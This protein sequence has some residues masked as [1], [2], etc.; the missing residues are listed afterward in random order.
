M[1]PILHTEEAGARLILESVTEAF[2]SLD[3]GYRFTF[4]NPTAARLL[5]R[6]DLQGKHI[7]E[8]FPAARGT[9][10]EEAYGQAMAGERADFVEHYPAPLD[11]WY[12]VRAYPSREG[13]AVFFQDIT[14]R[15]EE[16]EAARRQRDQ[17]ELVVRGAD[18]G[19]WYCPLPFDVLIWDAKVKEHF[20]LPPDAT[21]TID[22]FYDRI[23]PD[24]RAPTRA[25]I[26]KSVADRSHYDIVYRTVSPDGRA[27]KLIHALGRTFYGEDGT[28]RQFDG[29]TID[30]TA[31][32]RAEMAVAA[33]EER[34][35]LAT[36]ATN[37]VVW[38]WDLVTNVVLWNEALEIHFGH[39]RED[40]STAA[41]WL[42]A[43]HPDDHDRV[44]SSI[45]AV[46]ERRTLE[47]WETEYRFRRADGVYVD[48]FDRGYVVRDATGAATRMIGAMQDRTAQKRAER[49]REH[50]LEAERA[51]RAEIARQS[52]MKDEFLATVSHELRTPL[53]AILGWAQM[54]SAKPS[55]APDVMRGL[56]VIMRNVRAQA[57][58]VDDLLDMSRMASGKLRLD[59]Q[60]VAISG[61]LEGAVETARPTAEAR[62]VVLT[63]VAPDAAL[64]VRGDPARLS[65]VLWNLLSN[66]IRF[67]PHGGNVSV[68]AKLEDG[69]VTIE[70]RD[71]GAGISEA[72]LPFVFDRFRQAD[73]STARRHGGLGLG[74]SVVKQ[75]V[76]LHGGSVGVQ[77]A[78][79]GQGS[80]FTV[81]LP[82]ADTASATTDSPVAIA[83][84]GLKGMRVLV[85]DDE[86][87][88]RGFVVRLL[89]E[90]GA[91][92]VE[93]A[94]V[95]SALERLQSEPFDVVVSDVGMPDED[96]YALIAK[97]RS[98]APPLCDVPVIA[99]TAFTRDEDQARLRAVGFARFL[100]K[101]IDAGDL[102]ATLAQVAT[103]SS[104]TPSDSAST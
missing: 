66:A 15:R 79:L 100:P 96:G 103:R 30:A 94:S 58:I 49:E 3:R 60:G 72:F 16:E 46:M 76:E 92:G 95:A 91:V 87:D 90:Y 44:Q 40:A 80:T 55:T 41:F 28:P 43:I 48:V 10:F 25:A 18:V 57:R 78:G 97:I 102:V 29:V 36:R 19:V 14:G 84:T 59:D 88:A 50:M 74:L 89:A 67:T 93:A 56:E 70:V 8:E 23:H 51:A 64:T 1:K 6:N 62:G 45:N 71:D 34:F 38:D 7:W 35:R 13:I 85:V 99:A 32:M 42:A 17:F 77:S 83:I 75:I 21:V 81:K 2:F 86:G 54:L 27:T 53:N 26:A 5:G 20:H 4:L 37:D 69:S 47:H 68:Q 101:P 104:D 11:R 39:R 73:G 52:R 63:L 12:E 22:L 65:Q 98:L 82:A 31:R 24:D 61:L 9:R 33:S